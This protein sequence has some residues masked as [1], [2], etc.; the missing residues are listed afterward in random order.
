MKRPAETAGFAGAIAAVVA[1]LAG[2][3]DVDTITYLAVVIG[4]VPA[5]VTLL[6][7][8]GGLSGVVRLLWR[9]RGE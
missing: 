5:A 9:G 1:R 2:V 3:D 6:V 8:N 4:V 7:S